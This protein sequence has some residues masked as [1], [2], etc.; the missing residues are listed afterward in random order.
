MNPPTKR[1]RLA[2]AALALACAGQ[3]GAQAIRPNPGFHTTSVPRNDDGSG[4][5]EQIGF[6]INFFGQ[7]RS[8]L[9]VN[10]NGNVTL[11]RPL[12]T[13]TPFG[14]VGTRQEIIAAFFADVDTRHA[15]SKLV[16][17]GRDSIDG[18]R[19]FG[20]NYIDVGYYNTHAD[21]LNSFQLI[22]IDRS[23]TGAGNFDIEFNYER[24]AW[25]TGD[26]SGGVGGFGGVPAAV[27]WSNGTG[28]PGT[29][30]ELPGSLIA[31]SFLDRGP[32]SLVRGRLNS[33]VRGRYIFKARNGSIS[34]GL[35][36][37]SACPMPSAAVGEA[38]SQYMSAVG[39]GS[40]QNWTLTPDPGVTLP[41][42]SLAA[43]GRFAGTPTQAGT[44]NFTLS[45]TSNTEDGDQT[46]TRRCSVTVT[47]PV[48]SI[49]TSACPLPRGVVGASYSAALRAS[50]RRF[51]SSSTSTVVVRPAWISSSKLRARPGSCVTVSR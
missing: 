1:I 10:N 44:F 25:E 26:A 36:I 43:D 4:P 19:A 42:L 8:T 38:Y 33:T 18:K 28:E 31:G 2:A 17:Y 15:Q 41:G 34:P 46:V 40:R 23:E 7:M 32:Y 16:T 50:D 20:V 47:P 24:I 11:D 35:A 3:A 5:L 51:R 12:A 45:L 27:G 22:L 29:S 14:L 21:K 49:S 6:T 9:Y 30:F 48:L 13:Y 37:T 39:T